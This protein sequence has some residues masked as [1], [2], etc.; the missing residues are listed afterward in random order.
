M[1][2]LLSLF[3]AIL[4]P[5]T[6]KAGNVDTFGI[7]AKATALGGAFSAYADDP[8]AV[9]YNPAGLTQLTSPVVSLGGEY[10]NPSLK[11]HSFKAKDGNGV[12]VEPYNVSFKD[13]SDNLFVPHVGFAT[14]LVNN[15]YFGI[16]AYVPY[17]LHIKW[18]SDTS[19]NPAAYNGFES[20]YVR[21]V[22]T[23]TI[24]VKLNDK[25]SVGFGISFGRSDAGTQRRIYAPTIPSLHNRI[26]KGEL[27]DDFNISFNV[28]ILYKPYDNLSFGLT[29]RSRTQTDFEGTVEVVGVDKVHATTEIDHPEQLQ[30]GVMYRPNKRL[31]LTADVVWTNWSIID[32][33]T[34]RFDRELLG[35]K[36]EVFPRNWKDTRQVRIGIEYKLNEIVTLRGGYFYD[37]SPIPDSTFDMLWPD[38]DKKTYSFGLGLNFGRLSVDTVLQY[39]IAEYKREI[40]GESTELNGSYEGSTGEPGT[41]AMS[42]DGHLWGYGVTINYRF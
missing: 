11:V 2:K 20:Y 37:P 12:R 33:Y 18:N 28:G 40:G 36:E 19:V 1:K 16:A 42:A 27:S 35:E 23:P 3:I 32:S 25:L 31:T 14:P 5:V 17:G 24:A 15:V 34:V 4:L 38:A 29:Y 9:Y 13:S 30:A 26:I 41:V 22:V 6:A 39:I 8:F 10:L 7:G 21:G